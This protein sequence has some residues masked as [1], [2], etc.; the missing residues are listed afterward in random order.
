MIGTIQNCTDIKIN[1]YGE[2]TFTEKH[3][4]KVIDKITVSSDDYDA[5][6]FATEM[7]ETLTY[8]LYQYIKL[9]KTEAIAVNMIKDLM[10]RTS[11]ETIN[12]EIIQWEE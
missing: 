2:I 7:I 9:S 11:Q 4:L 3:D 1:R 6:E 12:K 10:E 5:I 8:Q